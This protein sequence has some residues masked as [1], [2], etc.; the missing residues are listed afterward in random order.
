MIKTHNGVPVYPQDVYGTA[1]IVDP[2][3]HYTRMR[4]LG[5]VVWLPKQ[6]VYALPR[7]AEC[8]DV[9]RKDKAYIS[10]K[11]VSLN[12]LVNRLLSGSSTLTTDGA[13]H[14]ERRKLV[15]HG[16]LPRALRAISDNVDAQAAAVVDSAL[17]SGAVDGVSDIA[18]PLPMAV[19]PDLIGWP[20]DQRENLLPWGGAAFDM[21]GP[22]NTHAVKS[23]P[24]GTQMMRFA[25]RLVRERNLIEGSLAHEVLIA[26]DEGKIAHADCSVLMV[27]YI[28]PSLDTTIA[29]ISNALYLFAAHPEQWQLLR[30]D[31][32]LIPNAINE[33]IRIESPLRAFSRKAAQEN[34]IADTPIPAGARLLVLYSSAN[35]DEREWDDPHTFDIRRDAGRHLGFGNGTHACAG[36]ALARLEM[37]AMLRALTERVARIEFNGEPTWAVNNIIRRHERLPIRL[38]G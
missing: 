20:R 36:Q 38:C 21:L 37:T 22:L 9:L 6:R 33:V 18:M 29:A 16:M 10:G 25:R 14:D 28:A 3:P 34:E 5:S 32:T 24:V 30:Q 13:E 31:Q 8:K 7:Y 1:A 2:Y 19:V 27:D 11:G 12:P 35:R 15:A 4:E 26:V 17:V 23:F